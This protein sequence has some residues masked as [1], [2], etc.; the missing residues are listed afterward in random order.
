MPKVKSR[1]VTIKSAK[2]G[3]V[4]N[5]TRE[6]ELD[7]PT[8]S[9]PEDVLYPRMD[10]VNEEHVAADKGAAEKIASDFLGAESDG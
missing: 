5:T 9:K 1:S 4:V 3:F 8:D 2:N 7:R 10:W 6:I